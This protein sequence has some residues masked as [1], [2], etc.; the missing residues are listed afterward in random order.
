M[1]RIDRNLIIQF[2][3]FAVV[4]GIGFILDNVLVYLGIYALGMSRIAAGFFSFPFVVTFT[5][6]GNRLFTFRESK[7]TALW[8]Q[9]L[10]FMSVCAIGLL[11]NRGT[12]CLLVTTVSFVYA[13]PILGLMAGTAVGMFFNFFIIRKHV[14]R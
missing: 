12:Y 10:K 8:P 13:Y 5:W 1:R 2:S 9:L 11:F 3:K 4:G 6:T 7:R 14:F